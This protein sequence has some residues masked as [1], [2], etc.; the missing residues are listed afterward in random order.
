M[1]TTFV[2]E[3]TIQAALPFPALAAVLVDLQARLDAMIAFSFK[4][5][6]PALSITAQ[7]QLAAQITASLNAALAIGITPP[8]I[9]A[10]LDIVLAV[11]AQLR[12]ELALFDVLATAGV[13]AYAVDSATNTVGAELTTALAAGFPGHGATD[14]A[15]VLV[16]GTVDPAVWAAMSVVFK[17]S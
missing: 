12:A 1:T 16:L 17:T 4:L 8:S 7:L 5:G 6:L 10:Q 3:M 14:H 2:G 11:I 9:S 13:F 15:N